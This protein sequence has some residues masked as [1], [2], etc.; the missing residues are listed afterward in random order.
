MR[1][2][3]FLFFFFSI[4]QEPNTP[5]REI[6]KYIWIVSIFKILLLFFLWEYKS[7]QFSNYQNFQFL[8]LDSVNI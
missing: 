5:F 6:L 2:L 8:Y 7:F 3:F 4:F 1:K